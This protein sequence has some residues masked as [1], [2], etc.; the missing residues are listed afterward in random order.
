MML[1]REKVNPLTPM[2]AATALVQPRRGVGMVTEGLARTWATFFP[3]V[4]LPERS[5]YQYPQPLTDPFWKLYAEPL[6]EFVSAAKALKEA[7]E[8]VGWQRRP[9][10]RGLHAALTGGMEPV[11]NGLLARGAMT[12]H[13]APRNKV[14]MKWVSNSLLASLTAMLLEDLAQGRALQCPCGRLFVSQAYQGRY[15]SPRCRW[16]FE[17][18]KFRRDKAKRLAK[19]ATMSGS[20]SGSPEPNSV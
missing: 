1:T 9:K 19:A 11:I 15:C 8:A 20:P 13:A 2:L 3:D 14:A 5:S 17:K 4:P 18:S 16:R 7:F 12:I 10:L 6:D